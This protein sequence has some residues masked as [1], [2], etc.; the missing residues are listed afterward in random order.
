MTLRPYQQETVAAV[1]NGWREFSKQLVVAP[2]GSGK[3]IMFSALAKRNL[4][5]KTL[6]LAHRDELID[7]AIDKLHLATG[8][9]AQKEK[10]EFAASLSAEVVVASVQTMA[11]RLDKWPADHF[12]LVIADEAHHALADQW[13][14]VLKHFDGEANVLG[15]TATPDR[16]DKKNLG[17]YFE[18]VAAEVTMLDLI[19][20][21]YLCPMMVETIPLQLDITDCRKTAGDFN[22]EDLGHALEPYLEQ[23]ANILAEVVPFRKTLAF[24]PLIATSQKFVGFCKAA[25]LHAVHV[26][27]LSPDR[28]EILGGFGAGNY[29]LCANS[30]LLLE[31]FDDPSIDCIVMLRPTQSR[32]LYAQAIGRG[33]R[34]APGKRN[35]LILDFLWQSRKHALIRPAHLVAETAELAEAMTD[36]TEKAAGTSQE[37]FDLLDLLSEAKAKRE[38]NLRAQLEKAAKKKGSRVDAM[39]FCFFLG[40]GELADYEPTFSWESKPASP[41]QLESLERAGIDLET[42]KDRGHASKLMDLIVTR[43][44]AGLATFKQIRILEKL[45]YP[46]ARTASRTAANA[47]LDARLPKRKAA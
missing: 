7:Q 33:T 13:Q 32:P 47:F 25:G 45:G 44:N 15:V 37:E 6:I 16:G 42:V 10:A 18:A 2:T 4:P 34:I 35:L 36:E 41:K 28:S 9:Y 26:D 19:R 27:G 24:L 17:R 3:T 20:A 43:G 29:D 14:T 23:I 40:A 31:G 22:P 39:E 21:G 38:A 1:Q 30:A 5:S 12:G 11:R 46:N 8:I